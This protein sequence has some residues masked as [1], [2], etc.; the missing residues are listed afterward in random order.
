MSK[1][2][3]PKAAKADTASASRAPSKIEQVLKLMSREQGATLAELT[4]ATEWQPHSARAALTGLRKKGHAIQTGKR[5]DLT[6]YRLAG[7]A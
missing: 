7:G 3:N 2:Q 6:C 5:D 4:A 1:D